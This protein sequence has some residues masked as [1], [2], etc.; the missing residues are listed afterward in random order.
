M[1]FLA[2]GDLEGARAVIRTAPQEVE[3]AV[4][5]AYVSFTWDLVWVLDEKQQLLLLRLSPS[6]FGNDVFAWGL[7]LAQ[8]Y[9]LRGDQARARVYA[10][11]ARIAVQ[12]QLR[13]AEDAG[14]RVL[15]GLT[16][17]YLG[18]KAEAVR[19][20]LRGVELEPTSK[21]SNAAYF[22]HQLVRIYLLVGEPD[23]ALEQL[24]PLLE[25]PYYLS[26]SWLRID[27]A[28]APLRGNPRFERLVNAK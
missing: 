4:L 25:I 8:T 12:A 9:A 15:Y 26:P 27:P 6:A 7:C 17:A 24:E 14:H 11:S 10:D 2:Q 3:P 19:E 5:A 18:R 1:V 20:G 21:S 13:E 28:F 23:R 22:Q 16:L